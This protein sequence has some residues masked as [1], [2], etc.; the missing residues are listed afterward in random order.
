MSLITSLCYANQVKDEN[1]QF[2]IDQLRDLGLDMI[3]LIMIRDDVDKIAS[4]VLKRSIT[5]RS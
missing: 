2:L 3:E 5:P 1:G 4:T